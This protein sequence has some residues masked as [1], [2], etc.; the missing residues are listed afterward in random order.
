MQHRV[1]RLFFT[2]DQAERR[3][4]GVEVIANRFARCVLASAYNPLL[5]R[6]RN[7]HQQRDS[8]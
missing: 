2:I 3:F 7:Q 4:Q 6:K 8:Y 5:A 1:H